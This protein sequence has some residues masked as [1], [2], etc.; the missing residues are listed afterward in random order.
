MKLKNFNEKATKRNFTAIFFLRWLIFSGML[1]CYIVHAYNGPQIKVKNSMLH[2]KL[3][4]GDKEGLIRFHQLIG[5]MLQCTYIIQD[6]TNSNTSVM[7]LN[8]LDII[9][10]RKKSVSCQISLISKWSEGITK[11]ME[12]NPYAI[13]AVDLW[14]SYAKN[15]LNPEI[16]MLLIRISKMSK[17]PL[18]DIQDLLNRYMKYLNKLYRSY[19][20]FES[21]SANIENLENEDAIK[22]NAEAAV[23]NLG[24]MEHTALA[25]FVDICRKKTLEV[26]E[27]RE[28]IEN[29]YSLI[30]DRMYDES[31]IKAIELTQL[32][33]HLINGLNILGIIEEQKMAS[34]FQRD[35]NRRFLEIQGKIENNTLAMYPNFKMSPSFNKVVEY[36][37]NSVTPQLS[38]TAKA[39]YNKVLIDNFQYLIPNFGLS[40]P[41]FFTEMQHSNSNGK[42]KSSSQYKFK[43]EMFD[44]NAVESCKVAWKK[45]SSYLYNEGE[46]VPMAVIRTATKKTLISKVKNVYIW[47]RHAAELYKIILTDDE[48]AKHFDTTNE[49]RFASTCSDSLEKTIGAKTMHGVSLDEII[50]ICFTF[51]NILLKFLESSQFGNNKDKKGNRWTI[52]PMVI[53]TLPLATRGKALDVSIALTIP[54][55][56]DNPPFSINDYDRFVIGVSSQNFIAT[57]ME[58]MKVVFGFATKYKIGDSLEIC[59]SIQY[60]LKDYNPLFQ[61]PE[62]QMTQ[63]DIFEEFNIIDTTWVPSSVVNTQYTQALH[64]T[65]ILQGKIKMTPT[66]LTLKPF[67][68]EEGITPLNKL[69]PTKAYKLVKALHHQWMD[70]MRNDVC[71]KGI[72]DSELKAN[73]PWMSQLKLWHALITSELPEVRYAPTYYKGRPSRFPLIPGDRRDKIA[74]IYPL[75]EIIEEGTKKPEYRARYAQII[76]E[77]I[78]YDNK[79]KILKK[80]KEKDLNLGNGCPKD[81]IPVSWGQ[82]ALLL[83]NLAT[84][85]FKGVTYRNSEGLSSFISIE[86]LCYILEREFKVKKNYFAEVSEV[87]LNTCVYWFQNY[88]AKLYPPFKFKSMDIS[89]KNACWNSGFKKW[90]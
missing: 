70:Q 4:S 52:N 32:S 43:D 73:S 7:N 61:N 79:R 13:I 21:R 80:K 8:F 3:Y 22:A 77:T 5:E 17:N 89:I 82:R 33:F 40:C 67:I 83:F 68:K 78:D 59:N 6:D 48:F 26:K 75:E 49:P 25:E 84:D 31:L 39:R 14:H 18:E 60:Y 1:F 15:S 54:D 29:L 51:Y 30:G 42:T 2:T 36:L 35:M 81:E 16:E 71:F 20:I 76:E 65:R 9:E 53:K 64:Y 45:I 69:N 63:L 12:I 47:P 57:C 86:D 88:L 58:R 44:Q 34:R 23:I 11:H 37:I 56:L 90:I 66:P 85:A 46:I 62:D 87:S 38:P 50:L 27:M 10:N 55:S 19:E 24:R 74:K 72:K 28:S 41:Y